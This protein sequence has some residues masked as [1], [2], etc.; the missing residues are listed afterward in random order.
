[1]LRVAFLTILIFL[2]V[3]GSIVYMQWNDYDQEIRTKADEPLVHH[4]VARYNGESL[5][6]QHRLSGI[7]SDHYEVIIPNIVKNFSCKSI[8]DQKCVFYR[9]NEKHFIKTKGFDELE[10]QYSLPLAEKRDVIW[11]ENWSPAFISGQKQQFYLD[12][13]DFTKN[14]G[15]WIAG[16]KLEGQANRDGFTYYAW[17]QKDIVSVPLYFQSLKLERTVFENIELYADKEI[18]IEKWK[19]TKA[20]GIADIPSLT[21]VVSPLN[22]KYVS[23]TLIVMPEKQSFAAVQADYVRSYY[24]SFYFAHSPVQ[25]WVWDFLTAMTLNL[26][27]RTPKAKQVLNELNRELTNEEKEKFLEAVLKQ[28]G[29]ELTLPLLDRALG[30]VRHGSTTFFADNN[31]GESFVP[32]LFTENVSLFVNGKQLKGVS[33]ITRY[34]EQLLPFA[35]IMTKLGYQVHQSGEA[36]FIDKGYNSWRFFINSNLYRKNDERFNDSAIIIHEINDKLYINVKN[37]QE[38][39]D[40]EVKEKDHAIYINGK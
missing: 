37:I 25:E 1:M 20:W 24:R 10:M 12:M 22:V 3:S 2:G 17:S 28:K 23:P 40:I 16:A 32:L 13:I 38:W 31:Q 8:K 36:V 27:A 6:V 11:L 19:K 26:E 39:F 7:I 18:D 33:S 35:E 15:I 29:K 21:I 4:I 5:E 9:E 14:D 34:G 30:D